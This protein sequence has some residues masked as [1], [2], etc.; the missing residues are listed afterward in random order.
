[1][2]TI[3]EINTKEELVAFITELDVHNYIQNKTVECAAEA[4]GFY[5]ANYNWDQLNAKSIRQYDEMINRVFK[6]EELKFNEECDGVS[7]TDAQS[8][9][10]SI[11]SL[12]IMN[13]GFEASYN[14]SAFPAFID[15][16]KAIIKE[17]AE[18]YPAIADELEA[19]LDDVVLHA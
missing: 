2:K 17:Y 8:M 13:D 1:M 7:F 15:S 4:L 3:S 9:F 16:M 5:V 18:V 11:L 6:P 14:M 10:E 19:T 12:K